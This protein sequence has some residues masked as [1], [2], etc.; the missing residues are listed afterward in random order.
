MALEGQKE[1]AVGE[2]LLQNTFLFIQMSGAMLLSLSV[3]SHNAFHIGAKYFLMS[4]S[5][6]FCEIYTVNPT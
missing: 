5:S 6:C 3:V 4:N 2:I 1:V